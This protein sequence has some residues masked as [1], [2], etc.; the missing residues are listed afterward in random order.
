M[1]MIAYFSAFANKLHIGFLSLKEFYLGFM[2]LNVMLTFYP[3][4]LCPACHIHPAHTIMGPLG[5][6]HE[7]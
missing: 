7:I 2:Y 1:M 6:I 5:D 3:A 4:L